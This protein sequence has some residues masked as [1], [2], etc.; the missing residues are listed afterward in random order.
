MVNSA[1]SQIPN[2]NET[3]QPVILFVCIFFAIVTTLM[4]ALRLVSRRISEIGWNREDVLV[5]IGW[6]FYIALIGIVIGDVKYGGV[7]LHQERVVAEDPHKMVNWAKYLI[8]ISFIYIFATIWSKLAI[9]S[10]YVS[11]FSISK[12]SRW[13]CYGTALLIIL[14]AIANAAAGF[15]MC[16]PLHA[17][18]DGDVA[19][20]CFNLNSW[21]RYARVVNIVS[22]VVLLV[23]PLPH[24]FRLQT[25]MRLKVGLLVTFLSGSL[26]LIFGIIAL[27]EISSSNAV[28]DNTW[29]AARMVIWS[30]CEVG[31]YTIAACLISYLPLMKLIWHKIRGTEKS[32]SSS[33][34]S[35]T[36]EERLAT[37]Q[38]TNISLDA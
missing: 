13:I 12:S 15:G 25:T 18:W 29:S 28:S 10:L 4:V 31:M 1:E 35:L 16:R 34:R 37:H 24:V 23:L 19:T 30:L 36:Y 26:G 21:F 7:G 2:W 27:A 32:N 11:L 38:K 6:V 5:V 3:K 8:A 14:N 9:L 17:L 33:F 20:Q 22:D